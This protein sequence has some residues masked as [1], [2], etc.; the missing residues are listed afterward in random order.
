VVL[1]VNGLLPT[2]QV[3][4]R[5]SPHAKAYRPVDIEAIIVWST[6]ADR[7]AHSGQQGAVN[8]RPVVTN[9]ACNSTH[10]TNKPTTDESELCESEQDSIK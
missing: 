6:M 7:R 2:L 9:Y 3:D 1:V 4:D 8:V 5:Q 10:T